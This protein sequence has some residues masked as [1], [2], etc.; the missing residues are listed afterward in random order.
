VLSKTD[1]EDARAVPAGLPSEA[2]ELPP[3]ILADV[4]Y[5]LFVDWLGIGSRGI[6]RRRIRQAD[7]ECEF[8]CGEGI[9][10]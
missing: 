9:G 5:V 7:E 3:P 8:V 1:L 10:E 6:E 2:S 4:N